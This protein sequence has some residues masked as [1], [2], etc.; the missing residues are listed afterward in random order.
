MLLAHCSGLDKNRTCCGLDPADL[1]EGNVHCPHGSSMGLNH[2]E[3]RN[4]VKA[5]EGGC[6]TS[7][8]QAR[9]WLL[10]CISPESALDHP[11]FN[12]LGQWWVGSSRIA[13]GGVSPSHTT[14]PVTR[15]VLSTEF[16]AKGGPA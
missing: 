5:I 9:F 11:C 1:A 4:E 2:P 3:D 12:T 14:V 10:A 13:A 15:G 16:L 6:Y 8:P 7:L